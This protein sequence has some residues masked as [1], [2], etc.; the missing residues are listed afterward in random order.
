[1]SV[2]K[3]LSNPLEIRPEDYVGGGRGSVQDVFHP[4]A[5]YTSIK[6]LHRKIVTGPYAGE[7]WYALLVEGT[8]PMILN[9]AVKKFVVAITVDRKRYPK[10]D[11]DQELIEALEA[12][13]L[14]CFPCHRAAEGCGR[15]VSTG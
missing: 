15:E 5:R 3:V 2:D 10:K 14:G 1:M 13:L 7:T 11:R 8:R 6:R 4:L 12:Y 9:L